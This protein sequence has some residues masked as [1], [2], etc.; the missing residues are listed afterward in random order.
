MKKRILHKKTL[1]KYADLSMNMKREIC[2]ENR[3]MT[4]AFKFI[5]DYMS[6]SVDEVAKDFLMAAVEQVNQLPDIAVHKFIEARDA[7]GDPER[8][9]KD[10]GYKVASINLRPIKD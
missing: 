5:A 2:I 8:S 3:A 7:T 10:G 6:V 4:L 9:N 1:T